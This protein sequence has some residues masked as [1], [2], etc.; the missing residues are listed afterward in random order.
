MGN[1]EGNIFVL[2]LHLDRSRPIVKPQVAGI[3]LLS[4]FCYNYKLVLDSFVDAKLITFQLGLMTG[5][6]TD[7]RQ[8]MIFFPQPGFKLKNSESRDWQ[9]TMCANRRVCNGH[10]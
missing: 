3:I 5:V 2:H 4:P 9:F 7:S 10:K 6:D 1:K 8:A